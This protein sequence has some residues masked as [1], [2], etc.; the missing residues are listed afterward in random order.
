MEQQVSKYDQLAVKYPD[1]VGGSKFGGFAVGEGWFSIIDA[2]CGMITTYVK[3]HNDDVDYRLQQ[4]ADGKRS[5]SDYSAELLTKRQMPK[6]QQVKEKFGGLRF[7]VNTTDKRIRH[8][9]EFAEAMSMKVCEE[10]G[11]PGNRYGD[12]WIRTLCDE[13][14]AEH[15]K[16]IAD[17]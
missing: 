17:R 2:L 15:Q 3:S 16:R 4:I 13:H 6:I 11:K 8:W 7:Y 14:E 10:C 12:G 9:I 1:L 5:E